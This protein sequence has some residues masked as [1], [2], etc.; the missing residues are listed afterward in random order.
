MV[1][2]GMVHTPMIAHRLDSEA[3]FEAFKQQLPLPLDRPAKPEELAEL[4]AFLAS[5]QNSYL[6]GQHIYA[7]GG[8]EAF[9]RGKERY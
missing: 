5:P 1:A 8:T 9:V 4:F 2:P 3:A 6:V 7:D